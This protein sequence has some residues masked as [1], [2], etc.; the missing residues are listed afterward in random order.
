MEILKR[1]PGII[2]L[3]QYGKTY[4]RFMAG[5]IADTLYQIEISQE[6]LDLVMNGSVNGGLIVNYPDP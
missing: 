5:G 3:K 1:G 6:E 2:V 4:I